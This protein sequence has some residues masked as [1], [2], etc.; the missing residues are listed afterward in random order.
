MEITEEDYNRLLNNYNELQSSVSKLLTIE[1]ELINT[2]DQLDHE[3]ILYKRLNK[4]NNSALNQSSKTDFITLVGES[5]IDILEV[6]TSIVYILRN[7]DVKKGDFYSEG[8]E[9]NEK[10]KEEFISQILEIGG[11]VESDKV[12]LLKQENLNQFSQ[13]NQ[14]FEVLYFSFYDANFNIKVFLL[15][16]NTI[17]NKTLYGKI[18]LNIE[19]IFNL[20]GNQ[21]H[22]II[23]NRIKTEKINEQ[24]EKIRFS[25]NELKK[26]SLIATKSKN[27]VVISDS[28]G[29][30]EWV[31]DAF[32]KTSGYELS[33]IKGKKPKDFLQGIETDENTKNKLKTSLSRKENVEVKIVNYHKNGSIYHILLEII[34]IF[35]EKGEFTNFISLQKDITKEFNFQQ[36]ILHINSRFDLI[37]NKSLIGIWAWETINNK[38]EWNDILVEQ[39]GAKRSLFEP[40]FRSFCMGAIHPDDRENIENEINHL[41]NTKTEDL[42]EQ[43][44]RIIKANNQE[45]RTIKCLTIAERDKNK[46]L[47]RLIGSSIDVTEA[48]EAEIKIRKSEEKFRNIIE[49]MNLGLIERD[50]EGNINYIN[51]QFYKITRLNSEESIIIVN[52][53]PMIVN[54]QSIESKIIKYQKMDEYS[55]EIDIL[56]GHGISVNLLLNH[57]PIYNQLSELSGYIYIFIDITN[58]KNIRESIIIKNNELLKINTELDNFVYSVSHDL[59]TPLLSIQ[60]IL[61]LIFKTS[62]LEDKTQNYL[63]MA[64]KSVLRL[65]ETIREILDYSR[66]SRL[67][68]DISSINIRKMVNE[69]FEDIKFI[70][71][72]NLNFSITIEGDDFILSDKIRINNLL[73]NIIG[74]SVKYRQSNKIDSFVHF[75]L[76]R[77]ENSTKFVVVDNGEGI[78]EDKIENVFEMFYRGSKKSVGSGLGLYL[79]KE[80]VN[81]LNGKIELKSKLNIGTTVTVILPILKQNE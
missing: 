67:E 5:I 8:I 76:K 50:T 66:N 3:L 9:I 78:G 6:E 35:N 33:E 65:D 55:F 56:N 27:G 12:T 69:I 45:I 23:L 19:T 10:E 38:I 48:R 26:L 42:L 52:D 32:T 46:N 28:K 31:N 63:K 70:N 17:K 58:E 37:A 53:I 47:L 36:D 80:I 15:G 64:E 29:R 24:I 20:Y 1:Q 81:K 4:F 11:K 77:E 13:F 22:S 16:L 34:S 21:V 40:D 79:C 14:F 49:N 62:V 57:V 30:I 2:R 39:Y 75:Y 61:N 59:R 44:Y 54:N 71:S 74:N 60:G 51:N 73:K 68:L 72:E 43:E 18:K 41:I 25:E 7:K